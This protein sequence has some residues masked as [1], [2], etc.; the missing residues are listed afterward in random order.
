[1]QQDSISEGQG[2]ILRMDLLNFF[3]FSPSILFRL[4][5]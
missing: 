3:D 4:T 1:M 5:M 2:I